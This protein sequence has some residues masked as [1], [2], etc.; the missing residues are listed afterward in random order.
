M[1]VRN[2]ENCGLLFAF[3]GQLEFIAY[4]IDK[5]FVVFPR[6]FIGMQHHNRWI[7]KGY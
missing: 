4:L 7:L 1:N 6:Y 2:I 3:N 5:H